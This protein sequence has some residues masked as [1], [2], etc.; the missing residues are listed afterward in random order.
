MRPQ[1]SSLRSEALGG[2][3]VVG[4]LVADGGGVQ[5]RA[6]GPSGWLDEGDQ[7]HSGGVGSAQEENLKNAQIAQVYQGVIATSRNLP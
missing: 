6:R 5:L 4:V 2:A 3:A 1:S 7:L